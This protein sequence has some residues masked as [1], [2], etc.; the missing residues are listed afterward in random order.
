MDVLAEA[1]AR[2]TLVA[3][4]FVTRHCTRKAVHLD[5]RRDPVT[6]FEVVGGYSALSR[7][8]IGPRGVRNVLASLLRASEY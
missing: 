1:G 8:L 7:S 2:D 5:T 3:S 4:S 6:S